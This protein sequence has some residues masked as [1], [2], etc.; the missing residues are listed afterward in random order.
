MLATVNSAVLKEDPIEAITSYKLLNLPE[1]FAVT[2]DNSE[3]MNE[4]TLGE[5]TDRSSYNYTSH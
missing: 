3:N 4:D 1:F 2:L 5:L